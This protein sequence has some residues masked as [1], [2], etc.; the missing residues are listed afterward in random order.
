M[1]PV[2]RA[3]PAYS[4]A[5]VG[6]AS[7]TFVPVLDG[8]FRDMLEVI[9]IHLNSLY[10]STEGKCDVLVFDNGSCEQA[11]DFLIEKWK[12]G[13]IDWLIL[14]KHNLSKAGAIN[15]IFA[16]IPNDYIVFSD[17]DIYFRKGWLEKSLEIHASFEKA[18][19]VGGHPDFMQI[20]KEKGKTA[21]QIGELTSVFNIEEI[22]PNP[23]ALDEYC[24]GYGKNDE[25]RLE[26]SQKKLKLATNLQTGKKAIIG[27]NH[28]QFMLRRELARKM[29]PLP[30]SGA[31]E[32]ADVLA[33]NHRTEDLGYWQLSTEKPYVIH[34]G[35]RIKGTQISEIERY[36]NK[37]LE[38]PNK[39]QD[40]Q[41]KKTR[42]ASG[43][44]Q[45]VKSFIRLLL[46][47]F[48]IFKRLVTRMYGSLFGLLYDEY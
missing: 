31:L 17:S 27:S 47:R 34:M 25:L 6:F 7:I 11:T 42:T 22:E 32:L 40:K 19:I 41:L 48:P 30:V 36:A 39:M 26:I 12:A 28:N 1:N 9:E 13:F 8:F 43:V 16:S 46:N 2:K 10:E 35:N 45:R 38:I 4:P 21:K 33:I 24:K 5:N 37:K 23:Q 18:G 14:S 44:F 29:V 15:W 3:A 20:L